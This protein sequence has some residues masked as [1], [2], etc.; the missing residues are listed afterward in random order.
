MW[1]V[2]CASRGRRLIVLESKGSSAMKQ[3]QRMAIMAMLAA[4]LCPG[5]R[6]RRCV[7]LEV[8]GEGGKPSSDDGF[9]ESGWRIEGEENFSSVQLADDGGWR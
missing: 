3:I 7:F 5:L 8:Y 2:S 6:G 4:R 9:A 1:G